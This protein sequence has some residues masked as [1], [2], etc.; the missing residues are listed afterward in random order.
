M[1]KIFGLLLFWGLLNV[2]AL[3]AQNAVTCV[4]EIKTN[5]I[6]IAA[7]S[8]NSVSATLNVKGC[9]TGIVANGS[10]VYWLRHTY[11][12]AIHDKTP[13]A[14]YTCLYSPEDEFGAGIGV[15]KCKPMTTE[16]TAIK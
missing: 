3:N 1:Y 10:S 9:P 11:T 7:T 2:N 4:I 8:T 6:I 5:K 15:Y 13:S 12:K 14:E 16:T